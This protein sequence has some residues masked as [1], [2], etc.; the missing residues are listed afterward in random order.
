MQPCSPII[1]VSILNDTALSQKRAS[2]KPITVRSIAWA[3]REPSAYTL[4]IESAKL[5]HGTIPPGAHKFQSDVETVHNLIESQFY[6][7]KE[8]TDRTDFMQ[9]AYTYQL[10]FNLGRPKEEKSLAIGSRKE[11]RY[12]KSGPHAVSG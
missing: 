11:S 2:V 8:F 7:I 12:H 5:I 1:S 4:A 9:K 10:F 6:E 3:A